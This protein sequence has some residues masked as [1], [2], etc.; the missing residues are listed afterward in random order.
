MSTAHYYK[1][2]QLS[3]LRTFCLAATEGNFTVAARSLGL[4]VPT[5]WQQVRAL[6]AQMETSLL[7]RRGRSLELTEEGRLLLDLIQPHVSG[8]ESLLPL[9]K[10]RCADLTQPLTIAS[11]FYLISY[12]LPRPVRE[13][14]RLRPSVRLKLLPGS[15][16]EA[17]RRVERGEADIG[18]SPYNPDE[19]RSSSLD[20][21]HLFD[22]QFTLL[23]ALDHPLARA[24][25]VRASDL[26]KY[27]IIL[28]SHESYGRKM[29]ERLLLR[30]DL[31]DRMHVVMESPSTDNILRYVASGVGV[32]LLYTRGDLVR[33]FPNIRLRIF[34]S[35]L[36]GLPV[37]L[38]SRKGAHLPAPAV[39]FIPLVR[40][41]LAEPRHSHTPERA[42]A[43]NDWHEN[44]PS[45]RG[46]N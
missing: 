42:A 17:M 36:R 39:E 25:R 7:R 3:Q 24:K 14:T 21:E 27:P 15:W 31:L 18:I 22:M 11:T 10:K 4:S 37:A 40:R 28:P 30:E 41:F 2:I 13:F 34:D 35:T 38:L 5:V 9:F 32:A 46:E 16:P 44:V 6:E 1:T 12:H 26:V 20:Y 23:V 45:L 33:H 43:N 8:L 29:L 19:S